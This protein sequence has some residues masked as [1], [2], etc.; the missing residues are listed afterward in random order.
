MSNVSQWSASTPSSNNAASPN[1]FPEG[2]PPSGVNDS[3]REVMSAV[4]RWYRDA[5]GSLVTTG[6]GAAYV[7][8]SNSSHASLAAQSV[9][10]F[11]IHTANTGAA[12][13]NVDGTGPKSLRYGG[14]ALASGFLPENQIVAAVY[15]STQDWYD[16]IGL[17]TVLADGAVTNAKLATM[18]QATIKGRVAGSGTGAP[19]DLTAAQVATIVNTSLAVNSTQV[20]TTRSTSTTLAAYQAHAIT[21]G[22]TVNTGTAGHWV[23][24]YN[25]SASPITLTQGSGV[26][27]RLSGTATTG[28]RTLAQRS[29]AVLWWNSTGEVVASGNGVS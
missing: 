4:A 17:P 29:L 25:D 8:A 27:L 26:T 5:Q 13:L 23:V 7:L 16:I 3:A 24:I 9:F 6:T 21:A 10:A 18:A 14:T 28:N 1:G 2:M 20:T 12:T 15:N 22:A 19:V 11:R